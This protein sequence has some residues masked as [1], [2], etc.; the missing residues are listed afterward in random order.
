MAPSS[1]DGFQPGLEGASGGDAGHPGLWD[2]LPDGVVVAKQNGTVVL[3]NRAA[4]ALLGWTAGE[5]VGQPL[6]VVVPERHRPAMAAVGA[7]WCDVAVRRRDG[8]EAAVALHV[9][10]GSPDTVVVLLRDRRAELAAAE[11][12][13][14]AEAR[15]WQ[16]K[17]LDSLADLAGTVAH[18]LNNV[19]AVVLSSSGFLV[20]AVAGDAAAGADLE[21]VRSAAERGARLTR[22][23]LGV[24]AGA[25][26]VGGGAEP[27]VVDEVIDD[28]QTL[29]ERASGVEIVLRRASTPVPVRVGRRQLE[30]LVL[31]LVLDDDGGDDRRRELEVGDAVLTTAD[32]AGRDGVVVPGRYVSL[33]ARCRLSTLSLTT[34]AAIVRRNG[35]VLQ[36]DDADDGETVVR[37]LLPA[38]DVPVAP[39]DRSDAATSDEGGGSA[40]RDP[41]G[42]R[43]EV[44]VVVDDQEALRQ[45]TGRILE[46]SGYVVLEAG[47]AAEALRLVDGNEVDVVVSDV[48]MP[49]MSGVELLA[50]LGERGDG[51]PVVLM[52]GYSDAV[53]GAGVDVP[54]LRKPFSADQLVEGVRA[55]IAARRNLGERARP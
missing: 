32:A 23:L 33:V 52:S 8:D 3:V 30:H 44:V 55:A 19:L 14:Q 47:S 53:L 7:G 49:G 29:V 22:R 35:G 21:R 46:R 34:A 17:R 9:A 50:A 54:L 13:A 15:R 4:E 2:A 43:R 6:D 41:V 27:V 12:A 31:A 51:P 18:E 25:S 26:D 42:G 39:G 40:A 16:A 28:L 24:G 10:P 48:V 5:L 11:R 45:L 36:V 37:V 38:A 20:E 1:A